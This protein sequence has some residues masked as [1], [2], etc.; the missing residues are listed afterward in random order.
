MNRRNDPITYL[1]ISISIPPALES[2]FA[3][4]LEQFIENHLHIESIPKLREGVLHINSMDLIPFTGYIDSSKCNEL[5]LYR[6][7]SDVRKAL[8]QQLLKSLSL[9][10]Q[11]HY[12]WCLAA[13]ESKEFGRNLR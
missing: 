12:K 1:D 9:A 6:F 4:F 5:D 8:E 2:D 13:F 7:K 10:H 11:G 3:H